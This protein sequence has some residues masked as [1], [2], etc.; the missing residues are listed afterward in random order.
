MRKQ[1]LGW[2]TQPLCVAAA[3]KSESLL[4]TQPVLL[5]AEQQQYGRLAPKVPQIRLG[6]KVIRQQGHKETSIS[7][8]HLLPAGHDRKEQCS[9]AK[10]S[11]G[12]RP[13]TRN[14]SQAQCRAAW[15]CCLPLTREG[16]WDSGS[17]VC[18]SERFTRV[19][20][21]S[22]AQSLSTY[23]SSGAPQ[24]LTLRSP[25]WRPQTTSCILLHIFTAWL[26]L[27]Q[28]FFLTFHITFVFI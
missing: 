4:T 12:W 26:L 1:R 17:L 2:P 5:P 13:V 18:H 15:G 20:G 21:T 23:L 14:S 3:F 22:S 10:Q 6:P 25:P 27:P 7:R 24:M 19:P 8:F 28:L 11:G 9:K 16:M